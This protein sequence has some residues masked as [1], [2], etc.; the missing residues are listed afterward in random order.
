V[1]RATAYRFS[2]AN[3]PKASGIPSVLASVANGCLS[4]AVKMSSS[5]TSTPLM[6]DSGMPESQRNSLVRF[7]LRR[8]A[9]HFSARNATKEV[10]V[11]SRTLT[12]LTAMT[13][14]AALSIP[15]QLVAQHTRYKL[16][17]I[18]TLGGPNGYPSVN[19]PGTQILNESGVVS[20]GADTTTPDPKLSSAPARLSNQLIGRD[21]PQTSSRKAISWRSCGAGGSRLRRK[22]RIHKEPL[23]ACVVYRA[24][25]YSCV[26]FSWT[27][28]GRPGPLILASQNISHTEP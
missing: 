26:Q 14:F 28:V 24:Y 7:Q 12:C 13:L 9:L 1:I 3:R 27:D 6:Q 16:T 21:S 8:L 18:P 22:M 4:D 5:G 25:A 17:D 11:K 23:T 19:G 15:V 20:S 10:D 2:S